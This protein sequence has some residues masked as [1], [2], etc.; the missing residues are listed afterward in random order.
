MEQ[1]LLHR[2]QN[3]PLK[4]KLRWGAGLSVACTAP[5]G[6]THK[7][8]PQEKINSNFIKERKQKGHTLYTTTFCIISAL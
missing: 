6:K 2:P 5:V 3:S 1:S 8:V 7:N 4:F